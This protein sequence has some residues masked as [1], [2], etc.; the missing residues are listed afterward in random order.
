MILSRPLRAASGVKI[1]ADSPWRRGNLPEKSQ[2]G[3]M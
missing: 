2:K 1:Q 3:Y